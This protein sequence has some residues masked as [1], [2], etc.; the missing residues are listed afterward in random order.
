MNKLILVGNGFDLAHGL[1]TS[2]KDFLN[3]IWKNLGNRYLETEF[4]K[5]FEVGN[6][7]I[8][9]LST[10]K[11]ENFNDFDILMNKISY[12]N[13]IS[14]KKDIL[15]IED[16]F[17]RKILLKVKNDFFILIN[18]TNSIENWV[19]IENEYF[20]ELKKIVK[21]INVE[22]VKKEQ[23]LKLNKEFNEVKELLKLY[24][25]NNIINRYNS[26]TIITKDNV[27]PFY[28]HFKLPD[29]SDF[30][31]HSN[32]FPFKEDFDQLWI[33]INKSK[34]EGKNYP[35][36][37]LFLNFNYTSSLD[38]YK[39]VRKEEIREI[40]IHGNLDDDMVFGFG[41]ETDDDYQSIENLNDNEYLKNFKSFQYSANPNYNN[42]FT[43]LDS[44]KFH[45]YIMGHS[46]G[47]SDRV[48]LNN[49]FEHENCRGIKIFYHRK[50]DGSDNY[51]DIVHNI[52][53]HFEDKQSMRRK[54]VNKEY[55]VPIP[56]NVRFKKK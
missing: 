6:D 33:N 38:Y 13:D 31:K 37:V 17:Y 12:S 34:D 27:N 32:D 56:Q 49:I 53:R 24:L 5:V 39:K 2:Y 36:E 35:R 45:I 19:D 7:L 16:K 40:K 20:I 8:Y 4:Q 48:L 41:D 28:N 23:I 15:F 44:D 42:F 50:E 47:L 1:P 3:D 26:E 21:T 11:I 22:R 25:K 9:L 10:N 18:N 30:P 14:Y 43:F 52:S 51:L 29:F 46:C 54:I 55:S